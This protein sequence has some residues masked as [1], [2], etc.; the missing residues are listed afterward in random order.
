MISYDPF[1]KLIKE[2][3]ISSYYLRNIDNPYYISGSTL[4]RLKKGES[5]STNTIDTLCKMLNCDIC[6][7]ISFN[8][9]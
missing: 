1:W 5:I 7:I 9:D 2:K 3:N 4:T 8:N 6:D